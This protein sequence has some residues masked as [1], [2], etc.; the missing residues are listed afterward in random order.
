MKSAAETLEDRIRERA[1]TSGKPAA[2]RQAAK[3]SSGI[4][5][6]RWLLPM[7]ASRSPGRK[8]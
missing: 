4:A 5:R 8:A 1:S 6:V 2:D 3:W 7:T